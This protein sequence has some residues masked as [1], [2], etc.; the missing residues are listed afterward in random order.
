MCNA[1]NFIYSVQ[2]SGI[3][4]RITGY[5]FRKALGTEKKMLES[6]LHRNTCSWNQFID[7]FIIYRSVHVYKH[8]MGICNK[9]K[10][11]R[12][13]RFILKGMIRAYKYYY[14]TWITLQVHVLHKGSGQW[15]EMQDLHVTNILP[16]M[17]TLTEAYIQ[18]T[19]IHPFSNCFLC[20]YFSTT[21]SAGLLRIVIIK[22]TDD[23]FMMRLSR[24]WTKYFYNILLG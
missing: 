15:Y 8:I 22:K 6:F 9:C 3:M 16:Q 13:H 7:R 14:L 2:T 24:S 19:M 21:A 4:I 1:S 5:S 20:H 10:Y 23:K 11:R 17:I 18:V 12:V